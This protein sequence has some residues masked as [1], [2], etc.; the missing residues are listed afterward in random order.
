[1]WC[2]CSQA[3][4]QA[5]CWG[6][7]REPHLQVFEQLDQGQLPILLFGQDQAVAQAGLGWVPL[8]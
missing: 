3:C 2:A 6:G 5:A 8:A 1:M 7:V 4:D